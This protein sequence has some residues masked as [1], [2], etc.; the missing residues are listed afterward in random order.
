MWYDN[1]RVSLLQLSTLRKAPMPSLWEDFRIAQTI[2]NDI[3]SYAAGNPIAAPNPVA[4]GNELLNVSSVLLPNGPTG[5]AYQVLGGHDFYS[6]LVL[7]FSDLAAFV[8]G[9]PLQVAIKVGNTWNGVTFTL[10]P[11]A[12]PAA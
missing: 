7:V 8:A 10:V 4:I 9:A 2:F 1:L 11:K 3:S 12:P 5:T 6:L